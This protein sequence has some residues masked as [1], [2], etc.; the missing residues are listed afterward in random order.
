[1]G[2]QRVGGRRNSVTCLVHFEPRTEHIGSSLFGLSMQYFGFNCLVVLWDA[3]QLPKLSQL[4]E[5]LSLDLSNANRTVLPIVSFTPIQTPIMPLASLLGLSSIPY[6][7]VYLNPTKKDF[8]FPFQ[9]QI[10]QR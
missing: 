5:K 10:H 1:M 8:P 2:L 7:L 4:M 3:F 6:R 9:A